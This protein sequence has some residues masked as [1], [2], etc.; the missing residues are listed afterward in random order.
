MY[1]LVC[2]GFTILE[3]VELGWVNHIPARFRLSICA[4]RLTSYA[5]LSLRSIC[6]RLHLMNVW[7]QLGLAQ[8]SES[9]QPHFYI[10]DVS[11]HHVSKEL[12]N[13]TSTIKSNH[14]I[15]SFQFQLFHPRSTLIS[16]HFFGFDHQGIEIRFRIAGVKLHRRKMY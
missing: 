3:C 8:I 7:A 10:S 5:T 1:L 4:T 13:F 11:C 16:M 9:F 15:F 2:A 12:C 14:A 6:R